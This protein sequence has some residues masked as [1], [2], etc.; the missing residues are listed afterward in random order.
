MKKPLVFSNGLYVPEKYVTKKVLK[1]FEHRI[2]NYYGGGEQNID[3]D[4]YDPEQN[5]LVIKG[6]KYLS[7]KKQ[8]MFYTGRRDLLNKHFSSFD[9]D[10]RRVKVPWSKWSTEHIKLRKG[11]RLKTS[12]VEMV[13]QWMKKKY[14]II[15]AAARSGKTV[16][17][18][19]IAYKLKQK[20]LIIANQNELLKQWEKE[21]SN[22]VTNCGDVRTEKHPVVGVMRKWSDI[23]KYDIVLST[24]Q[25]WNRNPRKIRKYRNT[26]G[27]LFVDEIHRCNADCPK[28]VISQFN[29]KYKGG[30]TATVERKDGR[31]YYMDFI[32]GPVTSTVET[33][34]MKCKVCQVKTG[35]PIQMCMWTYYINRLC[36]SPERNKMIIKL[37]KRLAKK[38]RYIVIG[39]DRTNHIK[40]ITRRLQKIGIKAE[41]FYSNCPDRAGLLDRAKKG[42]IQVFVANRSMLT[43][44]NIP[45][46]DVYMNVL[47]IQNRPTYYQHYSRIRTPMQGK[48]TPI[49]Y[50]FVDNNGPS[51]GMFN[52]RCKQYKEEGFMFIP[53]INGDLSIDEQKEEERASLSHWNNRLLARKKAKPF[54]NSTTAHRDGVAVASIFQ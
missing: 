36:K 49:I 27:L 5:D 12:Q 42:K 1:D 50:D 35:L 43:G 14:G 40:E 3:L 7:A 37:A 53:S 46:L 21:F 16:L 6:Y 9:I 24:W 30:V 18:S 8:Y 26:F 45:C 52:F 44:I 17:M 51:H 19:Y 22:V 23:D 34:Q 4:Y 32:V 11:F 39:S 25:V 15:K 10:D 20:T 31:Q 29:C 47:P 38:G 33:E 41:G 48:P 28:N 13:D 2:V 54:F